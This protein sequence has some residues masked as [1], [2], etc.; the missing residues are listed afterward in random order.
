[1]QSLLMTAHSLCGDWH[2][3][4]DITQ[5][6]LL[7]LYQAWPRLNDHDVLDAYA[8]K[9]VLSALSTVAPKQQAV[10]V[11][12]H[13]HDLIVEETAEKLGLSTGTVKSQSARGL[14]TLR[15]RLGPHFAVL[16]SAVATVATVATVAVIIATV[17][18]T[19]GSATSPEPVMPVVPRV[20]TTPLPATTTSTSTNEPSSSVNTTMSR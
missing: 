1:V 17:L 10:L 18:G 20:T 2:H 16:A 8:R 5:T 7:E 3:A 15:K 13:W 4:E 6:A 19:A 9:V 11:L 12:R 14:A